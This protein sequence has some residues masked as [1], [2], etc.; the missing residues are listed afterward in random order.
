MPPGSGLSGCNAFDFQPGPLGPPTIRAHAIPDGF[1]CRRAGFL[2]FLAMGL[3]PSSIPMPRLEI[4]GAVVMVA[5]TVPPGFPASNSQIHLYVED[6]DAV[7][8]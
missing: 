6:V 8:A 2:D 3:G 5:D 4:G 1:P 7:D